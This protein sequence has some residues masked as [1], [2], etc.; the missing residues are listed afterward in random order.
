M[1]A[2]SLVASLGVAVVLARA[3][4]P[5][6]YGTYSLVLALISLLVIPGQFG[7]PA[8]VLRETARAEASGN[9][10][11]MR[12]LWRWAS[13]SAAG[14]SMLLAIAGGA[15]AILFHQGFS[16]GQ[17]ATFAW[18]LVLVP[19]LV[20]GN[21]RGAALQGL[22]KTVQ[23]QLP[24][25]IV[26][27][28]LFLLLLLGGQLFLETVSAEWA[29]ALNA[30]A[31]GV[32][33]VFGAWLLARA[34]P[35]ALVLRPGPQY[36]ARQWMR[37]VLPLALLSAL[38]LVT[39]H[40]DVVLLGAFGVA[41]HD[42]GTYRVAS[43]VATLVSFGL[44]AVLAVAQPYFARFHA[45]KDMAR[46]QRLATALARTSFV[47]ALL[48][49]AVATLFGTELLTAV[50]G[51]QYALGYPVLVLLVCGQLVHVGFGTVGPLLNMAGLER[52]T[53]RA[54]AVAAGA[55]VALSIMLIPWFGPL[56]AAAS[57]VA[58]LSIWKV[59]LWNTVRRKLGVDSSVLG[60]F[61]KK[62]SDVP[63]PA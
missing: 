33:F 19:V 49:A 4:G 40:A 22:R 18:G 17:L 61:G 58:S 2:T 15:G 62:P 56:G 63:A 35:K 11:L 51:P 36:A 37:A 31:A 28:L 41:A 42:I 55:N 10:G 30:L 20:L 3:L 44:G 54:T 57:T 1:Q 53:V 16:P 46:F 32:A 39:T 52:D 21:L 25:L 8:L 26:R 59:V 23:G 5:Q 34:R 45:Q 24:E 38:A 7:L 50:F 6:G 12:G 27:P 47:F 29:M 48:V 43:Q 14:L 9:W 13:F 60:L